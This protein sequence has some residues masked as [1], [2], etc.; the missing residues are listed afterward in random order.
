MSSSSWFKSSLPPTFLPLVFVEPSANKP[1]CHP[2][3]SRR[4]NIRDIRLRLAFSDFVYPAFLKLGWASPS[5][6][7]RVGFAP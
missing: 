6:V 5:K 3:S 4:W 2:I 1:I 7:L